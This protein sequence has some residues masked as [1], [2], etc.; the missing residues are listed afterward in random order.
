MKYSQLPESDSEKSSESEWP[1]APQGRQ[2]NVS[3]LLQT[4][5]IVLLLIS[6]LS[7]ILTLWSIPP[8]SVGID[9]CMKAGPPR[10]TPS[11][12]TQVFRSAS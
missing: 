4:G 10:H 1:P 5:L 11:L 8:K 2:Y 6:N 7:W 12:L 3:L 9:K